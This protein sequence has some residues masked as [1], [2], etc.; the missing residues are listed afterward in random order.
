MSKA[1]TKCP[2]SF[3][4]RKR[5]D[6]IAHLGEHFSYYPMNSNNGGFCLA[7]KIKVYNFD[8]MGGGDY[9]RNP[10]RDS[11]WES[12]VENSDSMFWDA[13]GDA[14]RYY[15]DSEWSNYPGIEQGEW[16]FSINGRSG[17][18]MLL[19]DAPGWAH[20]PR[21]WT[22]HRA[23]WDS[24]SDFLEWLHELDY[25]TLLRFYKA[26]QVLDSDLSPENCR[27]NLESA[28]GFM[29][30]QWEE[31]KTQEQEAADSAM[32]ER[33]ADERPDLAPQYEGAES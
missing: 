29:R 15:T 32:A 26:M 31:E 21:G 7:W 28:F 3:P 12:K 33:I 10:A 2:Y 25:A 16:K 8:P 20:L 17:G 13:C 5:A 18:Y 30:E 1:K 11:A 6:I 27:A 4:L 24:R 22:M 19:E 14:T 23:T 9:T